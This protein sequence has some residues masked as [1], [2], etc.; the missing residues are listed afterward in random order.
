MAMKVCFIDVTHWHAPS[1][2]RTLRELTGV[3]ALTARNSQ[4]GKGVAEGLGA[5]FYEDYREMVQRERPDFVFALGRHCE[6]AETARFLLE[7]GVLFAMEKPMGL[8]FKEAEELTELA[9]AK[10]AFVAVP[11]SIRLSPWVRKIREMEGPG[12]DFSHAS[13]R[14]MSGPVSRYY[15]NDNPWNLRLAEAGGGCLINIGI[16]LPDLCLHLTGKSVTKVYART[17]N[18]SFGEEVED[19]AQVSIE[20]ED[21]AVCSMESAYV[22]AGPPWTPRVE[23]SLHGKTRQY[24]SEGKDRM[25]W[26]DKTGPGGSL[27][28]ALDNSPYYPVFVAD[29][30]DALRNSRPPVAG[31]EDNLNALRIVDAAYRSAALGTPVILEPN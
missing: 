30:L 21:G 12:A 29:T 13:F 9:R 26:F 16:H 23:F 22:H 4:T 25:V 7:K 20:T 28:G 15:E 2:Y 1:Y 5:K 11:F 24:H 19:Y 27:D 3:A 14:F 8:N 31:I 6:M 17:S 18:D 10:D